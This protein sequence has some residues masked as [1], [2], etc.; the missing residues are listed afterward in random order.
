[1]CRDLLD[2]PHRDQALRGDA[3]RG[4]YAGLS[5][6]QLFSLAVLAAIAVGWLLK[7]NARTAIAALATAAA[8][9]MVFDVGS[10]EAQPAPAD[11]APPTPAPLAPPAAA[12]APMPAMPPPAPVEAAPDPSALHVHAGL[13]FG[14]ATPLNRRPDKVGLLAGPTVSVGFG[15]GNLGLWADFDSFGNRD[16]SHGTIMISGGLQNEVKPGIV[17][18]ARMGVG[19]TLVNFDEPAFRD[20]TGTSLRIETV[21]EYNFGSAWTIWLRPLSF[22]LLTAKDLGGPILTYQM[23]IGI[24]YRFGDR[25][26]APV[27]VAPPQPYPPQPY[28]PQPYPPQPQPQLPTQ[29]TERGTCYPNSTCNSGLTCASNRCVVLPK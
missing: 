24:A 21:G 23:R 20:V 19:A 22:D 16:A 3:G 9:A 2:R 12:P 26:K 13:L 7:R 11:P 14:I 15:F 8:I 1:M 29:G 10:A 4:I 17:L 6:G 28:P 18:G 27:V 5:S 25:R